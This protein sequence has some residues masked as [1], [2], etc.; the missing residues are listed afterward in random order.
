MKKFVEYMLDEHFLLSVLV[1]VL[2]LA[3][4][5][6]AVGTVVSALF[7]VLLTVLTCAVGLF[8]VCAAFSVIVALIGVALQEK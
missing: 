1:I 6:G 3:L 5:T 4:A 8:L 2:V 7:G